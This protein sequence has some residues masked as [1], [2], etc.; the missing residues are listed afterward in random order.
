MDKTLI[1]SIIINI[2]D[3]TELDNNIDLFFKLSPEEKVIL[4]NKISKL[5][6]WETGNFLN[7]IYERED[8]KDIQKL[9]R[10]TIHILK[11]AG[12]GID[13]PVKKG[14][15]ALRKIEVSRS[16]IGYIT[17]YD[18]D[19]VMV[20]LIALH[21]RGNDYLLV[22]ATIQFSAGL[23]DLATIVIKKSEFDDFITGSIQNMSEHLVVTEVSP[24]Y[25]YYVIDEASSRSGKYRD[26]VKELNKFINNLNYDIEK[27][28]D[29]YRLPVPDSVKPASTEDIF[30]HNFFKSFIFE[31]EDLEEDRDRYNNI[32]EPSIVLPPYLIEENIQRFVDELFESQ[33]IKKLLPILKR[34]L[35]D[36]ALIFHC[37][38]EYECYRGLIENLKDEYGIKNMTT[39]LLERAL[40]SKY[41]GNEEEEKQ[42]R[43][44]INPYEER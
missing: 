19:N 35:E 4:L 33:K 32:V 16:N 6:T 30:E 23:T 40:K 26:T 11:T 42:N 17:N 22:D 29:I 10:K 36:Y 37:C 20:A 9:I 43:L 31:W 44:I 15:S 41:E 12:V 34:T 3:N 21:I 25:A 24:K 2:K 13:E 28:E 14:E 38:K 39:Y 5:K 7:L 8:R 27:P 18:D 1:D